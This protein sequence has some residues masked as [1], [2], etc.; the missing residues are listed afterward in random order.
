[1]EI[2]NCRSCGAKIVWMKTKLGKTIPVDVV[3]GCKVDDTKE[4]IFDPDLMTSH[5]AT[6]PDAKKWRKKK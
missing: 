2:R 3:M 1:M 6:C 5:F 4:T